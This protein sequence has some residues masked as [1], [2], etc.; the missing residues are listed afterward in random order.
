MTWP[1]RKKTK[2]NNS[3][4]KSYVYA[5]PSHLFSGLMKRY[6]CGGAIVFI[7]GKG[8]G[9][10]GCYNTKR[11]TCDNNLLAPRKHIEKIIISELKEKILTAENLEYVYR[12]LERVI[13]KGLNKVPELIKKR[14]YQYEKILSEIQNYLNYIKVGNFS[15]A[16]PKALQDAEKK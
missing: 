1:V 11:K 16:V 5:N 3:K 4:Q 9:Y 13:A 7:S 12:N 2:N 10:Y 8:S 15:N 6:S 14:K